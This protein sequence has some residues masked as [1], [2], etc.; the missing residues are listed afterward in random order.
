M[1]RILHIG[2]GNFHRAHQAWYTANSDGDWR[3]TG[4]SMSNVD[5]HDA[6]GSQGGYTLAVRRTDGLAAEWIEVHDRLI[7]ASTNSDS[8]VDAFTDPELYVVTLT[9]TEKGYCLSSTGSALD[10]S[11][12]AIRKDLEG[13]PNSAI[14]LLAHGLGRRA[15]SGLPPLTVIS[16]D[17]ISG[18]GRR[19]AAAVVAFA[20][21][22]GLTIDPDN[23][24][25]NSMVDRITPATTENLATEIV[26]VSG[27][28]D[29]APVM[30]E[31]FSEWVIEDRFAG[32]RPD[33]ER[34]GTGIVP[35]VA[36]YELR[37]L[38]LLNA[39]HSYIA[40]AGQLAGHSFVHQAMADPAIREGVDRL[41]DEAADSLPA[42][43]R[44]TT[45][46]YRAALA[47]RFA[48]AEMR[49]SLAQI[50]MDGSLKLRERLVPVILA[51]GGAPQATEAVAAWIAFVRDAVRE[52]RGLQDPIAA[53]L[54]DFM[55]QSGDTHTMCR[56]IAELIGL[57]DAAPSWFDDLSDRVERLTP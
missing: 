7:L 3:I 17:N 36:P 34:A 38:R 18:N 22:A 2:L 4:V 46:A 37:K 14:G 55:T 53:H 25:P 13:N 26:R 23:C 19:L 51:S 27:R 8:V 32:P 49:H 20:D 30:T 42:I 43:V 5:V 24:F 29:R 9:V 45:P 11:N 6:I 48:V 28:P 54:Y 52:G 21:A 12:P 57:R 33:W 35:D 31:A 47:D 16:C 1:P 40:Y 44:S 15:A 39:A 50:A 41:W 56:A 10:L